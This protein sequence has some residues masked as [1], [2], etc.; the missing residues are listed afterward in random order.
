LRFFLSP[1]YSETA[2]CFAPFSYPS[3]S[4]SAPT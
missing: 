3:A 2:L 1:L 4:Y